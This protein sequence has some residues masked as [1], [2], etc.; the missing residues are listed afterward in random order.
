[1]AAA[2]AV[3]SV[4]GS[5]DDR[6]GIVENM[7]ERRPDELRARTAKVGEEGVLEEVEVEAEL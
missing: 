7:V 2:Q 6:L 1:M 4:R 3:G 5:V